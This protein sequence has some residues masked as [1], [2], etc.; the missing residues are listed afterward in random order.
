MFAGSNVFILVIYWTEKA[1]VKVSFLT[2]FLVVSHSYKQLDSMFITE[3]H[4][5][6][7]KLPLLVHMEILQ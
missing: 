4:V 3:C 1:L 5:Q 7:K 2:C 6:K